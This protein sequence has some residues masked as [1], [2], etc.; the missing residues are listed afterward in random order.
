MAKPSKRVHS[1]R[2]ISGEYSSQQELAAEL[3]KK[4]YA[5]QAV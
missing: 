4:D 5:V 3:R 1:A 2:I